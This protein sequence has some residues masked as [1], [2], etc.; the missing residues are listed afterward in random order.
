MRIPV[1]MVI[2][3]R[4]S[5]KHLLKMLECSFSMS[6]HNNPLRRL[7]FLFRIGED[8]S[9]EL[10]DNLPE[11]T[12]PVS[13]RTGLRKLGVWALPPSDF[14]KISIIALGQEVVGILSRSLRWRL[15]GHSWLLKGTWPRAPPVAA[16]LFSDHQEKERKGKAFFSPNL[17]NEESPFEVCETG[18]FIPKM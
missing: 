1:L 13:D 4:H 7:L 2:I 9:P 10:L 17:L 11:A 12:Q 18:V 5:S 16:Q 6:P 8:W 3:T 14:S 15:F